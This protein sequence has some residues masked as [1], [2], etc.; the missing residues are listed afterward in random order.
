[1]DSTVCKLSTLCEAPLLA[2][3]A[4]ILLIITRFV[5]ESVDGE[6]YEMAFMKRSRYSRLL[7]LSCV[8]SSLRRVCITAGL[9][10]HTCLKSWNLKTLNT[11]KE[12][13][14]HQRILS[15]SVDLGKSKTWDVCA[16]VMKKFPDLD[17]LQLVGNP[18][19]GIALFGGSNLSHQF[20]LFKGS[21]LVIRSAYFN[22]NFFPIFRRIGRE[23]VTLLYIDKSKLRF[24]DLYSGG[25]H[26]RFPMFPNLKRVQFIGLFDQ[27]R[28]DTFGSFVDRFLVGCQLT[29]V[30]M[31]YGFVPL[32]SAKQDNDLPIRTRMKEMLEANDAYRWMRKNMLRALRQSSCASLKVFIDH[33]RVKETFIAD[34]AIFQRDD[35]NSLPPFQ[36][37]KLLVLRVDDLALLCQEYPP[38]DDDC[39]S[40]LALRDP[41]GRF[42]AHHHH[43]AWLHVCS[44]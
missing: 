3:P 4:E 40:T 12:F 42:R 2:L 11:F 13:Y 17:E 10:R 36:K 22:H 41:Y 7:S 18:S 6:C 35:N 44:P 16:Q 19:Q 28:I 20:T 27:Y 34:D 24:S 1:M 33:D 26:T 23:I 32:C 37:M 15:L 8:H 31:S 43:S 29:H 39:D 38:N 21:S 5:V 14:A 25:H 30:E 9:F